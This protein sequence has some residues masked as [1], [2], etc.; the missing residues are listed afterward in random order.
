MYDPTVARL[1]YRALL[2]RR[3]AAD[4]VRAARPADRAS[5]WRSAA[6]PAPTTRP[7]RTSSAGFA[8]ATMVPLIGVIAGT[9]RDRARDRRRLGRLSAGQAGEAADDHLH[10]ADRRDRRHDGLLGAAHPHRRLHPQRQRPAD[11]RRLHG[12][13]AGRL[14]RV[15]RAL[16]AARHASPG[17]RWSS[18]SSTRWSGRRCSAAWSPG[19]ARSASS[20]GRW[21][22]PRRSPAGTWSRSDVGLPL[23]DGAAGGGHG[24]RDLVRGA[25]AAALTLAGE[26]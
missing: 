10:Q 16:P 17:T 11:R 6:S 4:P 9:G 25:E 18:G 12:R 5:P 26:E 20:S 21:R 19:R 3:R 22:W 7:P 13:R 2:G 23:G 8:L 1:T 24:G 15:Q 14:D